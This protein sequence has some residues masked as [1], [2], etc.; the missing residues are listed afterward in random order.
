MVGFMALLMTGTAAA[1][2]DQDSSK[3]FIDDATA[4]LLLRNYYFNRD[5][6]KGASNN[7]GNTRGSYRG[8]WAQG[9]TLTF[10]SGFTQ[11]TV[12]F[13]LD[14]YVRQGIKLDSGAGQTGT[15]LLPIGSD[16]KP[17][18]EYSTGGGALKLRISKTQIAYG[19]VVPAN[20]VF[21]MDTGGRLL[22]QMAHG[23]QILSNDL[24]NAALE[25]GRFTSGKAGTGTTYDILKSAY[26]GREISRYQYLGGSYQLTENLN[27]SLYGAEA[28]DM[29]RQYYLGAN[30]RI[31]LTELDTL[32]LSFN[33]Y[34]SVDTGRSLAGKIDGL[35]TAL[36]MSYTHGPHTLTVA[37]QKNNSNTPLDEVAFADG[38][39]TGLAMPMAM[40]VD[41]FQGPNE[42][43]Y[44]LRYDLD[45]AGYGIPG[46]NFGIRH[47]IGRGDGSHADPDGDYAGT[48]GANT[49]HWERNID[50]R[51]VIQS[52]PAKNLSLRLRQATVRENHDQ[53]LAN[54]D[55]TRFII[56][57]PIKLL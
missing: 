46:L 39:A 4:T 28:E 42:R 57:Y 24:E 29:W 11:G 7:F 56:E 30:Y 34:R 48:W 53:P 13:G 6:R 47:E 32:K 19:D 25:A 1:V 38:K 12:G 43:A 26:G 31:P 22:S 50:I 8:E 33:S 27:A 23:W 45:F 2:T 16:R 18:D 20:P 44:Q 15:L 10:N 9:N 55:E 49:R 37:V 52:G 36:A 17:N 14:A 41:E 5:Y 51:Y 21:F 40:M 3:G 54:I 35:A